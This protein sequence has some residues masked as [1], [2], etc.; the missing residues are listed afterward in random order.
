M[1]LQVSN[2]MSVFDSLRQRM[3]LPPL[4]AALEREVPAQWS[5]EMSKALKTHWPEYVMEALELGLF[6]IAACSFTVLLFHP[7]S[8]IA[9]SIT[10]EPL[11]R[12]LMGIAM[13]S[14]AIAIVFSPFGKR[15]GAHF[16]PAVTLTFL[17]LGKVE[18]WDA[19][20]YILSQFIG[21]VAGVL[22]AAVFFGRLVADHS[23]NYAATL[24]GPSGPLLAFIAELAITFILMSVILTVSNT[25]KLSRWTGL[26]AGALVA[27]YISIESP[28]SGMS[29]NPART[30]GSAAVGSIWTSLWIY[31]TAP[32]LGMLLAAETYKRLKKNHTPAC[33]KLHHHNNERC[34]F[35]C[36]FEAGQQLQD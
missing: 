10:A 24:P 7:A 36:E 11:R 5:L 27:T 14:T 2:S 15:S 13:G 26:F 12:M 30:F 32:P 3:Q 4:D 16:N 17:R 6:M 28:I 9:Q 18:P 25:K 33:A 31:F 20:F 19:V 21:A 29:M 23:V 34:I 8:P 1:E 22:I 35:R